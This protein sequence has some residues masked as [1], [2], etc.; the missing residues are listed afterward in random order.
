MLAT[1]PRD[2]QE[3]F[4]TH[5][6]SGNLEALMELYERDAV[7]VGPE[8]DEAI[9]TLAVR[10]AL[11]SL[12]SLPELSFNYEPY[13]ATQSGDLV[14]MHATWSLTGRAPDGGPVAMSGVTVE[15][16]RRGADGG[17]RYAIDCPF[18]TA[19]ISPGLTT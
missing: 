17:W 5:F 4:F 18:G 3:Q 13:F 1:D 14:L 7:F 8:G 6:T 19:S 2:L 11:K 15:V 10:E 12:L 16:A 9:G